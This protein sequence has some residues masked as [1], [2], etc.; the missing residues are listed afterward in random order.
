MLLGKAFILM[1]FQGYYAL[2]PVGET[3]RYAGH[4]TVRPSSFFH[5]HLGQAPGAFRNLLLHGSE[6]PYPFALNVR[7]GERAAVGGRA[8][9]GIGGY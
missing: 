2:L 1:R 3:P 5:C 6:R 9:R 7:V 4:I 8:R